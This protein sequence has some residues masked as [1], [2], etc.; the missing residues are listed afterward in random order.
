MDPFTTVMESIEQHCNKE[1]VQVDVYDEIR[2]EPN[3]VSFQHA[4][5]YMTNQ[6]L[7]HGKYD[8]VIALGGGSTIDTAKAA[9][10]ILVTRLR[11]SMTMSI[12]LLVR[13]HLFLGP[14]YH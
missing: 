12:R 6:T 5:E 3:N 8:A 13:D 2:V 11:I 9:T 4:I 7:E 1:H 14:Y 10:Y